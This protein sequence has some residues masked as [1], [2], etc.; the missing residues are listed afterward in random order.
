VLLAAS[1]LGNLASF[2]SQTVVEISREI[3]LESFL[4]YDLSVYAEW[5]ELAYFEAVF[6]Y[7]AI[8]VTHS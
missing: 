8:S 7:L 2:G 5:I 1:G 6:F 3:R 4:M